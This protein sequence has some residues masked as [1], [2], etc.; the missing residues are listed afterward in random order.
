MN[1]GDRVNT[2]RYA[3]RRPSGP[4]KVRHG[5]KLQGLLETSG[6]APGS[7]QS[8]A[9]VS[10]AAGANAWLAQRWLRLIEQII[11][12]ARLASGWE[13]VKAGQ[14][15]MLESRPGLLDAQVQGGS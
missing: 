15:V 11:E 7:P 6:L 2:R 9:S 13:Y 4:R 5:L 3:E 14:I 8:D 10:S 12:P 1:P